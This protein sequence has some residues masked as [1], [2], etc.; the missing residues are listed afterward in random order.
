MYSPALLGSAICVSGSFGVTV[1][2]VDG[3]DAPDHRGT[4]VEGVR[5]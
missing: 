4:G 5:K 1:G 3:D 2:L